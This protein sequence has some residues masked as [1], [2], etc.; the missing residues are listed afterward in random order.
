[1]ISPLTRWPRLFL[2]WAKVLAG[3]SYY[4]QPQQLG[5]AFH[6]G[7]IAGYFNDLTA[8][9]RWAG[10]S[11]AEGIPVNVLEDGRRIYFATVVVQKA[12]GH[13]DKWLLTQD[14]TDRD[15]FLRLCRWLLARQDENGGW[16]IWPELGL[17]HSS[18]YSA[19]TQGECVSAFVRAWMMTDDPEYAKGAKRALDLM[20][21]PI[22]SGGPTIAINDELFLEEK[23]TNPRSSILNGWIFAIFGLYDFWLAFADENAHELFRASLTTLKSHLREYDAG[24]WSRYDINDH[25]A[26]PFY[27]DLHI[28]QITALSMIDDDPCFREIRDRWIGYRSVRKNRIKALAAKG[29]QKLKEP[30][31]AVIVR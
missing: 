7:Q 14:D 25:L 24:Y 8:K 2:R 30:G 19:M 18:Q 29:I 3:K 5:K 27:H 10:D 22:E 21:R 26:S 4:H 23:P 15:E 20:C 6:A 11:D 12:I 28:H 16:P 31:E 9:T 1:M 17:S 13:W